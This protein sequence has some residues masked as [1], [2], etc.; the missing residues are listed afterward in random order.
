MFKEKFR[1]SLQ[2]FQHKEE[3]INLIKNNYF[4]IIT[5]ETESAKTTQLPEFI[6]ES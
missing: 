2:I 6:I 1:K 4:F 3:I 5:G